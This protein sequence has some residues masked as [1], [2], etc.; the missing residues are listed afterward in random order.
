[1][2][3]WYYNP[4]TGGTKI[5]KQM[6]GEISGRI[7]KH[8]KKLYPKNISRLDIRIRGQF[9]YVDA[10]EPESKQPTHLC[11]LRYFSGKSEWSLAFY[12]YSSDKYEPCF[13]S[14][15][16]WCGSVEEAF[17]TGSVNLQA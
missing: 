1:M 7:L 2:S 10:Y 15:G 12:T 14:S 5:P 11:R 4:Q 9:C 16:E 8:C 3:P 13:L 17:E 6:Y